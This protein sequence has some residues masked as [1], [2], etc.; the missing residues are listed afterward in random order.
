MRL[1]ERW[2]APRQ[3]VLF[4]NTV[5]AAVSALRLHVGQPYVSKEGLREM[6]SQLLDLVRDVQSDVG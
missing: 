6:M 2:L 1:R 3:A 4:A 5:I